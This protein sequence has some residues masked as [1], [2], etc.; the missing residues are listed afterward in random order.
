M[1][2]PR[3]AT[4]TPCKLCTEKRKR[5][6]LG[7]KCHH[8]G[9]T[10]GTPEKPRKSSLKTPR[11]YAD[12]PTQEELEKN[13]KDQGFKWDSKKKKW[14]T[15]GAI[16]IPEKNRWVAPPIEEG[17]LHPPGRPSVASPDS[18]PGRTPRLPVTPSPKQ[19][20]AK[21]RKVKGP[22]KPKRRVKFESHWPRHI[23]EASS[24]FPP[25]REKYK[26]RK[27]EPKKLKGP[28]WRK[29]GSAT[30]YDQECRDRKLNGKTLERCK[31][32]KAL[33]LSSRI[34][35]EEDWDEKESKM[36]RDEDYNHKKDCMVFLKGMGTFNY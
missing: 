12:I 29:P 35:T 27:P 9:G 25:E 6:G 15:P 34:M 28:E 21:I 32:C 24:K 7:A 23:S 14:I 22:L 1:D 33:L 31:Y 5:K 4:G 11:E 13:L 16:F 19:K 2:V 10:P 3:T 18:V 26:S 36:L 17:L 8:H 20:P 30:P